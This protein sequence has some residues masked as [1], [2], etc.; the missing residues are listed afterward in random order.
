[1]NFSMIL[2]LSCKIHLQTEMDERG[3]ETSCVDLIEHLARV[4]GSQVHYQ[5]SICTDEGFQRKANNIRY[6]TDDERKD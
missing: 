6:I 2:S 5:Q 4:V 3:Q 1:M